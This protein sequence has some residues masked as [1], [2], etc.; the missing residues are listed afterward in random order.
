MVK[1]VDVQGPPPAHQPHIHK[2][3]RH[4]R[5]VVRVEMRDD[6]IVQVIEVQP[7]FSNR[8]IGLL[9]QSIST[10]RSRPTTTIWVF[11][12]SWLGMAFDDP[13]MIT[14]GIG[15]LFD[16]GEQDRWC[17][18]RFDDGSNRQEWNNQ[19]Q[20]DLEPISQLLQ[21]NL[22]HGL[23]DLRRHQHG[24]HAQHHSAGKQQRRDLKHAVGK[25]A[26]SKQKGRR[27]ANDLE[28]AENR[29]HQAHIQNIDH[30]SEHTER[31]RAGEKDEEGRPQIV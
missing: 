29:P 16:N 2:Q 7:A 25:Q 27:I 21:D 11:S 18:I 28:D 5:H 17:H 19:P 8:T 12:C 31:Y 9:T 4:A 26:G 13:R 22:T 30:H 1:P 20:E 10:M 15:H 23:A 6:E 3:K 24:A 14:F